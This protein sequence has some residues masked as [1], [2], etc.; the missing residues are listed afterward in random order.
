[1]PFLNV[2]PLNDRNGTYGPRSFLVQKIAL[3][4]FFS[5]FVFAKTKQGFSLKSHHSAPL[6]TKMFVKPQVLQI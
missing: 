2:K 3:I 5:I 1:M 4:R 6:K